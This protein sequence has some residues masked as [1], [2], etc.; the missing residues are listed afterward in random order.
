MTKRIVR[1]F[2]TVMVILLVCLI[3]AGMYGYRVLTG[4]LAQL[5]GTARVSGLGAAV[6]IER[7]AAG[8]PTIKAV[9]PADRAFAIGYLHGQERFFQMDLLRRSAAGELAE[10]VG[11]PA[12]PMDLEHRR[13]QF[14]KRAATLIARAEPQDKEALDAYAGGVNAGLGNLVSKP[15]E[16]YVLGTTPES[17]S[18]ED[19]VLCMFAMYLD[20]QGKDYKLELARHTAY[21]TLPKELADFLTPKG[22]DWDAPIAG[23]PIEAP[24]LPGPEVINIR[25]KPLPH[26]PDPTLNES[27]GSTEFGSNNWAINASRSK[28]G[29]AIVADD[30]HLG[31]RVPN[32]WYRASFVIPTGDNPARKE[33]IATGVTLP[34]TPSMVVAS[35][36]SIAWGFT[37][38]EGD[39]ADL[40]IVETD[41]TD[42]EKRYLTADGPRDFEFQEE[43][44][45]VRGSAA[46]KLAITQTIWGPIVGKDQQGRPLALRWV[47][48]DPDGANLLAGR[49]FENTTLESALDFAN[50]CGSPAQNFVIADNQG[51]IAW[52]ILGRIPRRKHDGWLPT[53]WKDPSAG[54]DGYL[55]IEQYPRVINPEEGRIWTA[56]S[57]VAASGEMLQKVGFGGYD[58]G[59][60]QKQIRDALRAFDKA[61][62]KEMLSIQLDDRALFWTRW[63]KHLLS[64]LTEQALEKSANRE[65]AKPFI[66]NWG[67]RAATDSVGYRIVRQVHLE[68]TRRALEWLTGPCRQADPNFRTVHLPTSVEASI[69]TMVTTKPMHLLDPAY[70]SWDDFVLTCLDTVLNE[71]T[72]DGQ[73]ISEFTWGKYNTLAIEH[74]LSKP[75]ESL[76]GRDSSAVQAINM[77]RVAVSGGP[78]HMPKIVRPR[79]GASERM[80]VSPGKEEQGIFHMPTGQSGHPLSPFYSAGHED[81]VEG[82][83]SSFLPGK[84]R[85]TLILEPRKD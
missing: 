56:N 29:G 84:T 49:M 17:W 19:S 43:T 62:E 78:K 9:T 38:S 52:T 77:P 65:T 24:P 73:P 36:G 28:H 55:D 31:L 54:W 76:L 58:L 14:R 37:N 20:L 45:D 75:L 83:P 46:E 44:I 15:I 47:A 10:L 82:R 63:Q 72:N 85:Y 39:W 74:P 41:P 33:M 6:T 26:E 4:S 23:E 3:G 32:I 64:L 35:N 57:R 71:A 79:S 59:A 81:W 25:E 1:F 40:V 60:R 16:Y 12:V 69:W 48:H 80:V 30:M 34:G 70:P 8:I 53:S 68:I 67:E 50:S 61:D 22:S 7:D 18:P 51:R 11:Q 5:E 21:E 27:F 66:E 42:P 2:F 13:H